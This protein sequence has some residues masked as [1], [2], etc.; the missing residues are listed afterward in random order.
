MRR[1]AEEERQGWEQL[2]VI[3]G[4]K[5]AAAGAAEAAK[6]AGIA[7]MQT[8]KKRRR[9]RSGRKKDET[10]AVGSKKERRNEESREGTPRRLRNNNNNNE[11]N[12]R[13]VWRSQMIGREKRFAETVLCFLLISLVGANR[14]MKECFCPFSVWADGLCLPFI[15]VQVQKWR[16]CVI[17]LLL[18]LCGCGRII[19]AKIAP[20]LCVTNGWW[21]FLCG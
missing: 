1:E 12:Y 6:I 14:K 5:F 10:P 19:V 2:W 11:D 15:A 9:R 7:K 3:V 8:K 13:N 4:Q 21:L 20:I 18:L 16:F 17:L